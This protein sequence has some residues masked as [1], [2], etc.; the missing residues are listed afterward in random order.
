MRV[1]VTR[2][3]IILVNLEGA[4]GSE[5]GGIRPAF[6]LQNEK[7]NQFSPTVTVIPMTSRV[8]TK[9]PTHVN[10]KVE[11][12]VE[13]ETIVLAETVRTISKERVVKTLG[14]VSNKFAIRKIEYALLIH[15]GMISIADGMKKIAQI[16]SAQSK[17]VMSMAR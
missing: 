2:G 3:D 1:K 6:V 14:H 7:A 16:E 8:K 12:G 13:K 10:L 5:Q 17:Q 11:D 9:L 4:I 15:T